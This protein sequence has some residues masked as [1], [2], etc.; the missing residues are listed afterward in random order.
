MFTALGGSAPFP[1]KR[2][3]NTAG[4]GT[5]DTKAL[6]DGRKRLSAPSA[7]E[8]ARAGQ[9]NFSFLNLTGE[10][11]ANVERKREEGR[12]DERWGERLHRLAGILEVSD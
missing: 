5:S 12:H 8:S 11:R 9:K 1:V 10:E 3:K 7:L 4:Q 6:P 2:Q